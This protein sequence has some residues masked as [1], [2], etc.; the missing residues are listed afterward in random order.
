MPSMYVNVPRLEQETK[1][2]LVAKLYDA[3]AP[4]L[5]APHIYTFVNEYETL[6]E[7]GQPAPQKMVVANIE[8]GPIKEEKVNAIAEGM[9]AAV[10]EVLGEDKDLTLVFH[11]NGLDRIA[12]GGVTIA[13][14]IKKLCPRSKG[15]A[16]RTSSCPSF[17]ILRGYISRPWG[18]K[19]VID[20]LLMTSAYSSMLPIRVSYSAWEMNPLA[21]FNRWFSRN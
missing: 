9:R 7:N 4:V 21:R 6:Y 14:K 11:D 20:Y 15:R 19:N 12:I 10:R 8:A 13:T 5:K 2:T 1:N 18:G 16:G 17:A 3:A